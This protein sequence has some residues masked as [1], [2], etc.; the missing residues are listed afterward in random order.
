MKY[1]LLAVLSGIMISG[2]VAINGELTASIGNAPATVLIHTAGLCALACI[3]GFRRERIHPGPRMPWHLYMGGV[4]G[5][6][7]VLLNNF[8]YATLGVSIT[9]GLGFLGQL[10]FSIAIDQFGLFGLPKQPLRPHRMLSAAI[11]LV[12]IAVMMLGG[13]G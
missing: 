4:V 1:A 7:S 10:L 9:L 11:V 2:M 12:G 6:G 13:N 3:M 5:V 8:T